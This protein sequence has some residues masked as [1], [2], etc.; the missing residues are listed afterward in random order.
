MRNVPDA[1]AVV[2][3]QRD[4]RSR[5]E[6]GD[7]VR[8]L[9]GLVHDVGH[10]LATLSLL[11]ESA[12]TADGHDDP[13]QR[14]HLLALVEQETARMS[15][16]LHRSGSGTGRAEP[17]MPLLERV[18]T[19]ADRSRAATV[20]L[21]G[22]PGLPRLVDPDVLWRIVS[23]LVDNAA[24]ATG[25]G[26]TVE[27][28]ASALPGSRIGTRGRG[29]A[30]VIDV[31]DDGPGFGEGPAGVASLG[32]GVVRRLVASCGGHLDITA[33]P[34]GRGTRVRVTLPDATRARRAPR[35][36]PRLVHGTGT[37]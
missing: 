21:S 35:P 27:V 6:A 26:G 14:E 5:P 34:S 32:L 16:L 1:H 15:A 4:R 30:L 20:V 3:A 7:E 10:G 28:D 33:G 29:A 8:E 9:R 24:R 13:A 18:V 11:M 19:L 31:V 2:P 12:R 25:A 37:R 23:N 22:D 17:V 36:A